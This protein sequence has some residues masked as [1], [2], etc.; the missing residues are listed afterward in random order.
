MWYERTKRALGDLITAEYPATIEEALLVPGGA[1]FPEVRKDIHETD[2]P[3][4]GPL[5]RYVSIDYGLD[6]LSAH[7]YQMDI[8]GDAQCYREYDMPELTAGQAADTLLSITADEH[9]EDW[10]APPD[11]WNRRNDT[12]KSVADIFYEHGINLTKVSNDVFSGCTHMKEWLRV[13][14]EE[15]K[16]PA[17]RKSVV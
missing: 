17:D 8:K 12:G 13:P 11:L 10:L 3:L 2:E 1:Y 4:V 7:W 16:K 5:R 14:E 15:G 6:M 9:I